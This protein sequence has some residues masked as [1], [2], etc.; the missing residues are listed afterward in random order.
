V[1][2]G[3][4][5]KAVPMLPLANDGYRCLIHNGVFRR[6]ASREQEDADEN[7]FEIISPRRPWS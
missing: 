4:K 3:D 7:H 5:Q 6:K 1:C 2:W